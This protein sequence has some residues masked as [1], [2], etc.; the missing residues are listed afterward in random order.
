MSLLPESLFASRSFSR[1]AGPLAC[2]ALLSASGVSYG[3]ALLTYPQPRDNLDT[4]KDPYGPCGVAKTNSPTMLSA[5]STL[6]VTWTE[7]VDHQ[8]CF[9]FDL[10]TDNDV[11]WQQIAVVKHKTMP[12]TPRPYS[13]QIQIPSTATCTNCTFRM[14][15]IMYGLDT[16]P[17]PPASIPM[18]ATYYSCA[19]VTLTGSAPPPDMAVD[20]A[21]PPPPE[22]P[23]AVAKGCQF[24][25]APA[26]P[27][28]GLALWAVL[29]GG[30]RRRRTR[31]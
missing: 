7:T 6:N 1:L 9:I 3:H 4:H 11:T 8:G 29:L 23:G 16:D 2:L 31:R 10:S 28:L 14:R 17:C 21:S 27:P 15:Q 19:D 26:A 5:G 22:D 25:P 24:S 12:T 20:A 13:A 18:G 30:L